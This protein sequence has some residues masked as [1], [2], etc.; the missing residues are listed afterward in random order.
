M[1][2]FGF[3]ARFLGIPI[4][5]LLLALF[6]LRKRQAPWS[7]RR[8]ALIILLH[9]GLALFYTTP[10]DNYLVATNV[11]WYDP[12]LVTGITIGW[13][14]I[15]EYTFF[16]LQPILA[17]LFLL[18]LPWRKESKAREQTPASRPRYLATA[19]AGVIWLGSVLLLLSRWQPGTYLALEL[20]WALPP[21]MLQLF[22]GAD[23]LWRYRRTVLPAVLL[24]TLYLATT[25]ALA[26]NSG[27]WTISPEQS[28]HWLLFG[29]L[30]FEE[31]IFFMLT[32]VLV[33]FGVTLALAPESA[34]RPQQI[35]EQLLPRLQKR[36][37]SIEP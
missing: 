22:F 16:V 37:G 25:D 33:V 15:E 19:A 31:L 23:I 12:Q 24:P 28:L 11:W 1:T 17:S 20:S 29:V 5:L 6:L 10:W 34:P 4:L 14:P 9:I 3:L 18:L 26:I 36:A 8:P 7:G 27:I 32:N 13:V 21:I 35:K 30:P 2:Y